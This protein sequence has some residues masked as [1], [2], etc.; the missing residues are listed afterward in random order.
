M[1]TSQSG[2]GRGPE[3]AVRGLVKASDRI[4]GQPILN[5]EGPPRPSVVPGNSSAQSS[6]P[7][8][9]VPGLHPGHHHA[10]RQAVLLAKRRPLMGQFLPP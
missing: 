2:Y 4:P 1:D 8:G 5:R 7:E 3:R 9:P 6:K 10:V